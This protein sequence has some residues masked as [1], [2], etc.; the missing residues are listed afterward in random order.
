MYIVISVVLSLVFIGVAVSHFFITDKK[1]AVRAKYFSLASGI[2]GAAAA[3][4]ASAVFFIRSASMPEGDREWASNVIG[5]YFLDVLPAL[6]VIL[7]ILIL[8]AVFQPKMRGMRVIVAALASVF[9]LIFGSI[10][11]FLAENNGVS[12]AIYIRIISISLAIMIQFCG[13]FDFGRL[14]LKL[15]GEDKRGKK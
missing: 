9:L 8:S 12:V 10:S 2:A 4:A 6:G 14:Y 11:S 7:V 15:A 5:G 13:F 1:W 3:A